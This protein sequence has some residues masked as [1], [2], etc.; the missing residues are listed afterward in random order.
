MFGIAALRSRINKLEYE[1]HRL[2]DSHKHNENVVEML[3]NKIDCMKGKHN[4]EVKQ[5][6][7]G[8]HV[9]MCRFCGDTLDIAEKDATKHDGKE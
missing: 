8:K 7:A 3:R 5:A 2:R 6:R 9:V 4:Y 1:V